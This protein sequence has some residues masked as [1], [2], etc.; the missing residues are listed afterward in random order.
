MGLFIFLGFALNAAAFGTECCGIEVSDFKPISSKRSNVAALVTQCCG[1]E[2]SNFQIFFLYTLNAAALG[3]ECRS[4]GHTDF[5]LYFC[6]N[7]NV[8]T[9]NNLLPKF[10]F[11]GACLNAAALGNECC[12]IRVSAKMNAVTFMPECRDIKPFFCM[13]LLLNF[14]TPFLLISGPEQ[15]YESQDEEN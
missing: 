11:H 8:V 7:V 13:L 1:I 2:G 3:C 15:T 9:L 6:L 10:R 4:I 5:L 14:S 12:G